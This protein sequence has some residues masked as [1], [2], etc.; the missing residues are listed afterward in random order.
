MRSITL[1]GRDGSEF[2]LGLVPADFD[3]DAWAKRLT[4]SFLLLQIQAVQ[5]RDV[6]M[7]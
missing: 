6:A 2:F 7:A 4:F 3:I 5:V 1:I